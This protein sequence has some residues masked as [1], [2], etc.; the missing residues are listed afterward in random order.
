MILTKEDIRMMVKMKTKNM[1]IWWQFNGA[2]T[3]TLKKIPIW[4]VAV[5]LFLK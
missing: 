4:I 5:I 3:L 1:I 2:K